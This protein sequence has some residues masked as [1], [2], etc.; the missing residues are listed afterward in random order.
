MV[1]FLLVVFCFGE[2]LQDFI[3]CFR[4]SDFCFT[5]FYVCVCIFLLFFR[6]IF[7]FFVRQEGQSRRISV[8]RLLRSIYFK[9]CCLEDLFI[10][11]LIQFILSFLGLRQ[12]SEGRWRRF[13]NLFDGSG[14]G[15]LK[16]VRWSRKVTRMRVF[17]LGIE[18]ERI[19]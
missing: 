11:G 16:G 13:W 1:F 8:W 17:S 9:F 12:G 4:E 3:L 6:D 5:V 15:F 7:F 19:R 14:F 18:R 2:N 10:L